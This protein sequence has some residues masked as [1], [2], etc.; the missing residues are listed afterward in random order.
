MRMSARQHGAVLAGVLLLTLLSS[1]VAVRQPAPAIP[2][3][4]TTAAYPADLQGARLYRLS[5]EQSRL[6]ILVYR[7]GTM[8]QL[9][10]NHVISSNSLSGYV[11]L[12]D[13]LDRSGFNISLPVNELL[14]DDAQTRLAEGA[15]F[16]ST[17]S[18]AARAGTKTN[19][20]KPEQL[21]GERY[22]VIRL[23]SLSIG[24]SREQP[25]IRVQI[26]IKDQMREAN[27]SARL[28]SS[29]DT[30]HV[31]GEFSLRQTEF[32]IQPYSVAMGA[33]QVQD[34]L[35]IKFELVAVQVQESNGST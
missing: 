26:V 24:G 15:E 31:T 9:G 21:D 20:L 11:W 2:A 25:Q 4:V 35:T 34:Q 13:S 30:L 17:V 1:C 16:R 12:H 22:P 10:H 33:I 14:V 27:V 3:A 7:G 19:M 29:V 8:A 5:S 18:D 28:T 32:G 23:H 6:H